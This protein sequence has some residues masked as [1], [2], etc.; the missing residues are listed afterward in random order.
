MAP[1][2]SGRWDNYVSVPYSIDGHELLRRM[3]EA[4]KGTV[5]IPPIS[6]QHREKMMN[7]AEFEEKVLKQFREYAKI[8]GVSVFPIATP[9]QL[10]L[11]GFEVVGTGE[12]DDVDYEFEKRAGIKHIVVRVVFDE[13]EIF[14][15]SSS[16]SKIDNLIRIRWT[17]VMISMWEA[18][19]E[20]NGN[21]SH[22][23]KRLTEYEDES[24]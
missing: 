17:C 1:E 6:A 19:D 2:A 5:F 22:N 10:N 21:Q 14:L 4:V 23:L 18:V 7:R 24:R 8:A 3:R 20:S 13:K 9:G 11:M 16:N 12:L 15:N